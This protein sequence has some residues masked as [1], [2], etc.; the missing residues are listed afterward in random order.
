MYIHSLINNMAELSWSDML[1][2]RSILQV[3]SY[4]WEAEATDR[5]AIR[6]F[7]LKATVRTQ[8]FLVI[9]LKDPVETP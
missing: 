7:L 5:A 9:L 4:G 6:V 8:R 3:L 1:T 2:D